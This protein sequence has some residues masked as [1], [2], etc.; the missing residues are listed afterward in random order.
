MSNQPPTQ[1]V[2]QEQQMLSRFEEA[3]IFAAQKH[4]TQ[5]RKGT[6]IPY[7]AHLMQVAGLAL[8]NGA[9]EEE[10]IA[11][12]LHDVMEDQDVTAQ[13]LTHRFGPKVAAIV[14]GCSD[15]VS[16]DKAPWKERKEAYIAHLLKESPSVRLVSSCDKL[17]NARAILADY[18][19]LG[20]GLW[21]RFNAGRDELLWYYGSLLT[22]FQEAAQ[23][24]GEPESRVVRELAVALEHLHRL[25][26]QDPLAKQEGEI[27]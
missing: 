10:A 9:D 24:Q 6:T 22:A 4:R 7:I 14:A 26:K 20:E 1:T 8:E 3:L 12:L 25:A 16:T 27:E 18:Q 5:K 13:E 23:A 15:S 19:E 2:V 17:H 11:A 21:S